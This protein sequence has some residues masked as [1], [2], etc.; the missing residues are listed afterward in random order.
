MEK[1]IELATKLLK[2]EENFRFGV[3]RGGADC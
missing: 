2:K 1:E 3:G